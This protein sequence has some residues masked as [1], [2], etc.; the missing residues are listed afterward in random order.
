MMLRLGVLAA[1]LVF[2][3]AGCGGGHKTET[4][5]TSTRST[6]TL[7]PDTSARGM[8]GTTTGGAVSTGARQPQGFDTEAAAQGHCP[9]D[10]VVWLNTKTNVYHAKG[11]MYYGHTKAGAY[12]CR[13][14]ADADGD[15]AS[16]N[17]S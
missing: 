4:T 15:R 6:A 5:S 8:N 13:R 1:A 7:A 17:G 3:A 2:A 11:S 9:S 10:P 16:K 14:E 12:M